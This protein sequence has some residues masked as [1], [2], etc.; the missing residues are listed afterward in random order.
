V[1]SR[2][3][4]GPCRAEVIDDALTADKPSGCELH[5]YSK[6][7]SYTAF[8]EALT[9]LAYLSPPTDGP[10]RTRHRP[11]RPFRVSAPDVPCQ[12]HAPPP[13]RLSRARRALESKKALSHRHGFLGPARALESKKV[14]AM[15]RVGVEVLL[16]FGL[17]VR[18]RVGV[19]GSGCLGCLG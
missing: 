6:A 13:P 12:R 3:Q 14:C 9:E 5:V 7:R 19:R 15:V 18:V 16:E 10:A 4:M 11:I 2:A 1:S 17:E 8:T